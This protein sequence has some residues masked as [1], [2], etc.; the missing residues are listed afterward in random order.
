MPGLKPGSERAFR[1]DLS[2]VLMTNQEHPDL[3]PVFAGAAKIEIRTSSLMGVPSPYN[4]RWVLQSF[5]HCCRTKQRTPTLH[6]DPVQTRETIRLLESK[7][8]PVTF[9]GSCI[10]PQFRHHRPYRSWE[11]HARRSPAGAYR[12]ADGARNASAGARCDGPGA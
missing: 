7:L 5:A 3:Y 2:H 8:A 10:H 6:T 11:E 9:H 1:H 4:S 12:L